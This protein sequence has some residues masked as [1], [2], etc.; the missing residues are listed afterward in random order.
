MSNPGEPPEPPCDTYKIIAG[1][2]PF[3][4]FLKPVPTQGQVLRAI[5]AD[6]RTSTWYMESDMARQMHGRL[7]RI[8]YTSAILAPF[9][10]GTSLDAG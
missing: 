5:G 8:V 4:Y 9:D 3:D 2:L 7:N 10:E 1:W 6:G